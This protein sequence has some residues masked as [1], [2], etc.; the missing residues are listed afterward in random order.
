MLVTNSLTHSVTF[1]KLDW[2]NHDVRRC[3]LMLM[4]RIVSAT[5]CCR[6]GSWGLVIKLNFCSDLEHKVWSRFW[7]WSS[8]KICMVK[9]F[10]TLE[11]SW[12]SCRHWLPLSL[13]DSLTPSPISLQFD[14]DE[15]LLFG[16]NF[17]VSA[18]SRLWRRNLI[19]ICFWTC[20]VTH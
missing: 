20:D 2:C 4:M 15:M 14:C 7:N 9:R 12:L 8:G 18:W 11:K 10:S 1:S 6:F 5:V 3:L 16:W 17:E 19:K 13:T